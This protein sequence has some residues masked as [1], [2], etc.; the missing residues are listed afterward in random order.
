MVDLW[1][2]CKP[3]IVNHNA[4]LV[5]SRSYNDILH[6]T[7]ED[8]GDLIAGGTIGEEAASLRMPPPTDTDSV[9]GGTSKR[10]GRANTQLP[11]S[12]NY[13]SFEE[14]PEHDGPITRSGRAATFSL[15]RKLMVSTS[16]APSPDGSAEGLALSSPTKLFSNFTAPSRSLSR[17]ASETNVAINI[18]ASTPVD[19][20][21][22]PRALPA[23]ES[24]SAPSSPLAAPVQTP[25]V[26]V[27]SPKTSTKPTEPVQCKCGTH[28]ENV[29][30]SEIIRADVN[31]LYSAIFGDGANDVTM[32]AHRKRETEGLKIGEWGSEA[33]GPSRELTYNPS[34]KMSIMP[35]SNTPCVEKQVILCQEEFCRTVETTSRTPKVPYGEFFTVVNRYCITYETP[36][37]TRL[38]VTTKLDFTKKL[39]LKDRIEAGALEG[40]ESYVRELVSSFYATKLFKPLECTDT[41]SI[42]SRRRKPNSLAKVE[43]YF[44]S[45]E[46]LSDSAPPRRSAGRRNA[47]VSVGTPDECKGVSPSA[48]SIAPTTIWF[49]ICLYLWSYPV[50]LFFL[51]ANYVNSVLGWPQFELKPLVTVAAVNTAAGSVLPGQQSS[52]T[53]QRPERRRSSRSKTRS[54][55]FYEK[56]AA[57]GGGGPPP[58]PG[59]IN[60]ILASFKGLGVLSAML[61]GVM[62][63]AV[64]VGVTITVLNVVWMADIGDR[65]D[66]AL[67]AVREA[68]AN[69]VEIPEGVG[70]ARASERRVVD[71]ERISAAYEAT[72]RTF[73]SLSRSQLGSAKASLAEAGRS[74][75]LMREKLSHLKAELAEAVD[76]FALTSAASKKVAKN[77]AVDEHEEGP[78]QAE[79]P[80]DDGTAN[81]ASFTAEDQRRMV[82]IIVSQLAVAAKSKESLARSKDSAELHVS[83]GE[84]STQSEENA[85]PHLQAVET[86]ATS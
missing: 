21:V 30:I 44:T 26:A 73:K 58:E 66:K 11:P 37:S 22:D 41:A 48:S 51:A 29:V 70:P 42:R 82:E 60:G 14:S 17:Q 7:N 32:D 63:L 16:N 62:M 76:I 20:S 64:V 15:F 80:V 3:T 57:G 55:S 43:S 40:V 23:L 71:E 1:K 61:V 69:G 12:V 6:L 85:N 19:T 9:V 54:N 10:R 79:Q 52:P 77:V 39:L 28:P 2:Q 86:D 4:D 18:I 49:A 72:R 35:K 84:A 75:E 78:L 83:S 50:R 27:N 8:G 46:P 74:A 68:R 13:K 67:D 53:R 38:T 25:S 34:F 36:S 45:D 81:F 5:A 65:L 31:S 56:Q 59:V 47:A 33:C 24:T